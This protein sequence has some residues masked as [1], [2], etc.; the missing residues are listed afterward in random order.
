MAIGNMEM[1]SPPGT[2]SEKYIDILNN[3][4]FIDIIMITIDRKLQFTDVFVCH[5]VRNLHN[6]IPP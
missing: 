1:E 3:I 2:I 6:K 4:K 5:F